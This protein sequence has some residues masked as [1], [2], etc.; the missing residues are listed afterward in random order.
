MKTETADLISSDVETPFLASS[1]QAAGQQHPRKKPLTLLPLIALIF[2]EVSGGPFGTEVNA[3][4]MLIDAGR[5]L[6]DLGSSCC[7]SVQIACQAVGSSGWWHDADT[8]SQQFNNRITLM[9]FINF[10]CSICLSNCKTSAADAPDIAHVAVL[11]PSWLRCR[12]GLAGS[13]HL[14]LQFNS[15]YSGPA[16]H[17]FATKHVECC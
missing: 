16:A 8:L 12:T 13:M 7:C 1:S 15:A 3:C 2:F 17:V 11:K 14:H 4:T 6:I 9:L 10:L 5:A